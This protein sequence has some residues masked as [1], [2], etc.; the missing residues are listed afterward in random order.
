MAA[1][2]RPT[3]EAAT[4]GYEVA[5]VPVRPVALGLVAILGGLI[6]TMAVL[7]VFYRFELEGTRQGRPEAPALA[8]VPVV[9]PEPNLL[10]DQAAQRRAIEDAAAAR[11]SSYGWTDRAAGIAHIP[12]DRAMAILAERGW[13]KVP[14]GQGGAAAKPVDQPPP[15]EGRP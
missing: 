9:P 12:I 8:R 6:L 11:L 7:G 3:T 5:D 14:A 13:P 1:T 10:A 4:R 15:P 2:D